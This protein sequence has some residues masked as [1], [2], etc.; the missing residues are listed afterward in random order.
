[1]KYQVCIIGGGLAGLA[2]S[3]DLQKRGI[4]VLVIEKGNY[5]RHKVCG[6]YISMESF[7][8][9][10]EICPKLVDWRLPR[11]SQFKLTSTSVLEF[12]TN[13]DLGGFGISRYL[14]EEL[15]FMEA[16]KLGVV[17]MLH[18]KALSIMEHENNYQINTGSGTVSADIV[19]N[20]TG[21]KS[22]V[23]SKV[24]NGFTN[25]TNYIGF[26]YHV[27]L[28][29]DINFIEIHNFPGGYCGIS[30]IEDDK[31]CL[32]YIVNAKKLKQVNNS[33]AELEKT[34][35]NQ[36]KHLKKIFNAADFLFKEPLSISGIN[37]NIKKP[38]DDDTFYL[39]DAAGCIAPVTGNG[40]SMALRS[41][42]VLAK[43]LDTYFNENVSKTELR[44]NYANFWDHEFATRVKHSRYFQKLSEYPVFSNVSIGLFKTFPSLAGM[45]IG[46]THGQPF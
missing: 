34:V 6:E 28:K 37:F 26:K 3:I 22:N 12:K 15:L 18:T 8:Y 1:M 27:I 9:L 32:C 4:Q 44:D 24:E 21:R 43:H 42:S 20:A 35:L 38:V 33:I 10:N 11:M 46:Q 40:M 16:Q 19:C 39:G 13:L 17:F 7:N 25:S 41:A 14:L 23:K 30:A 31:T 2:L 29:R 45:A 5:P 36:N